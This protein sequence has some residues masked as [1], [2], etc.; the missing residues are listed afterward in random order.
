VVSFVPAG[1]RPL[2]VLAV[3]LGAIPYMIGEARLLEAG[4]AGWARAF[5][6]RTIF[7]ASLAGAVALDFEQLYFL[8][9]ILPVIVL[10][11]LIFGLIGG[12]IGR[13]TGSSLAVGLGAGT[14]LAWAL[15]VTF[16]LFVAG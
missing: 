13:R 5:T 11:F 2:I 10:F 3:A 1:P 12:W 6:A 4:H 9:I 8:L 14:V 16:P 7:L 15:A